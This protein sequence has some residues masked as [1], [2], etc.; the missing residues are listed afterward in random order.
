MALLAFNKIVLTHP[1]LVSQQ[2]D[3]I[4]DCL[5]SADISIRLR[6]LDLVVGMVSGDNLVSI[7]S[8]LMRQ[9]KSAPSSATKGSAASRPA[10]TAI[11]PA[12]DSDDESPEVAIRPDQ[13]PAQT[14]VLP[15]EYRIDVIGKI[16]DMCSRNNYENIEDFSWYIDVLT[17]LVRYAPI[18]TQS[19]MDRGLI[20]DTITS[21]D[22]DISG[23][24]GDELRS[25][26]VKVKA[27][28]PVAVRAAESILIQCANDS[29]P[30]LS[31]NS[32]SLRSISWIVGEYATDLGSADEALSS[33]LHLTRPSAPPENLV[34]YLQALPKIFS[35]LAGDENSPWTAERKSRISL[36][37]AR[38][39]HVL[40]S[41]TVHPDLEV[42]E[43]AVEYSEL[44]KLTNEAVSGQEA[45]S[46]TMI[47]DAPLLLTQAIPS[48]FSGL[49]LNSVASGAQR[50]V[51]MPTLLD[52]DQPI[53]PNLTNLLLSVE[54]SSLEEPDQE[55]LEIYYHQQ[56]AALSQSEP[57]VNRL[58]QLSEDQS[59]SYQQG[60]EDS[61]LDPDIVARRRAERLERHKDDPFYIPGN[62]D[63]SGNSTPLHNILQSNNGPDLD[64]DAIPI[65]QLDLGKSQENMKEHAQ[66]QKPIAKSRARLQVAADETLAV[67]G[68]S[69]PGN[70]E[71][72]NSNDGPGKARSSKGKHSLL[73]VDSSNIISFSLEDDGTGGKIDFEQQQREEAEMAKAMQE[74]ERL[75]LEMQ[76]A[77]ERIQAAQGVPPQGT[78]VKKKAKKKTKPGDSEVT[79][80]VKKKKKVRKAVVDDGQD[81]PAT[82][83]GDADEIK[84]KKKKKKK[85]VVSQED[86]I[87]SE[88]ITGA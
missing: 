10:I 72:E 66:Y 31:P 39:V 87:Q 48:L 9:L 44:L 58:E 6:A 35:I 76:R 15:D 61:Y 20:E 40:D 11:E 14:T 34:I 49:E 17:Q 2:E 23:R 42:Q 27:V 55:E 52:L 16:L 30:S 56:P 73:G 70:Y 57:A 24:I 46:D 63:I 21:S 71:S 82:A 65:M 53:N 18:M 3:V 41:F 38:I 80:V 59:Q 75:R 81:Q 54:Y 33:L 88:E 29:Y 25:V 5:D 51:P 62:E 4:M 36:L 83:P 50:N 47:Q 22:T 12:A 86:T 69:T 67:S 78:L 74:V 45:S 84:P 8:R 43:R 1:Y 64:I 19:S 60:A 37:M 68:T 85:P 26:A 13:G 77:N 28:R 79:N 7:V 32:G